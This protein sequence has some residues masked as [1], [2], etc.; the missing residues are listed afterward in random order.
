[1][2]VVG[3]VGDV[4]GKLIIDGVDVHPVMFLITLRFYCH[5][6]AVG[7]TIWPEVLQ[8]MRISNAPCGRLVPSRSGGSIRVWLG[9]MH[10]R[11]ICVL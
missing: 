10:V 2:V 11:V 8:L 5:S 9:W 6:R 3:D 4:D 7:T 1:M